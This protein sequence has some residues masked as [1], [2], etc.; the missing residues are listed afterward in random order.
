MTPGCNPV[1]EDF[2]ERLFGGLGQS[3]MK[4]GQFHKAVQTFKKSLKLAKEREDPGR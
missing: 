2:M 4:V 1:S 3:Y